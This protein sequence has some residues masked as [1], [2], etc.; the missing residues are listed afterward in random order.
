MRAYLLTMLHNVRIDYAKRAMRT[1]DYLPLDDGIMLSVPPT[2][3]AR[4]QCRDLQ[5]AIDRLPM[6]Q[7]E[8]L[9]LV[10]LEGLSYQE[11]ASLVGIPIGTVMSRLSRARAAIRSFLSDDD[12][13]HPPISRQSASRRA[14]LAPIV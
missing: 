2:Q 1:R 4:L 9:L 10:S 12:A 3:N 6:E 11:A 8:V 14:P 13:P 5:V 7:R